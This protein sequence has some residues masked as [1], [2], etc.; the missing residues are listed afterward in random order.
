MPSKPGAPRTNAR[1]LLKFGSEVPQSNP[2]GSTIQLGSSASTL[3]SPAIERS[4]GSDS[5]VDSEAP[6][7]SPGVPPSKLGSSVTEAQE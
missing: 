6:R 5:D 1:E 7:S 4:R 2:G 3:R